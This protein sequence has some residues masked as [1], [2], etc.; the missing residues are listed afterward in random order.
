MPK[1]KKPKKRYNQHANYWGVDNELCLLAAFCID[2]AFEHSRKAET[3]FNQIV[4]MWGKPDCQILMQ[5]NVTITRE[6]MA[7]HLRAVWEH[8]SMHIGYDVEDVLRKDAEESQDKKEILELMEEFVRVA[9]NRKESLKKGRQLVYFSQSRWLVFSLII[10]TQGHY[11]ERQEGYQEIKQIDIGD[12]ILDASP[13]VDGMDNNRNHRK[14][15]QVFK[16]LGYHLRHT[17]KLKNMA[18]LW[19]LARVIYPS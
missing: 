6:D 9:F 15:T 2:L 12:R 8:R 18:R 10:L 16:E 14:C 1:N 7:E 13:L 4:G 11:Q 19:Y 17:K 3:L 5:Q